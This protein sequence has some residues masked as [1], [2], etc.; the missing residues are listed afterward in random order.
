VQLF[1]TKYCLAAHLAILAVAPLFLSPYAVGWI[2]AIAAAWMFMEPSRVNDELPHDARLRVARAV[3][4]DPLFWTSVVVA[5][6]SLVRWLNGGIAQ[7]YDAELAKWYI[8]ESAAPMLPGSAAGAGAREF[9]GAVAFAVVAQ[10]CRHALG[11]LAR[12]AFLF[13]ASSLAGLSAAVIAALHA[14][15]AGIAAVT[16]CVE[17]SLENPVFTGSVFGAHLVAGTVSLVVA[18]E[19]KWRWT[20]PISLLAVGGNA[21]GLFLCAPAWTVA[22]FAAAWAVAFLYSFSYSIKALSGAGEFK[23]MVIAGMSLAFAAFLS[24]FALP[25]SSLMDRLSPFMT[26]DFFPKGYGAMRSE[27]SRIAIA[28]WK[29]HPW[30]GT[31]LASFPLDLKFAQNVEWGLLLPFHS[32]ALNGY[33]QLLAERGVLGALAFAVPLGLLLW[34]FFS[35]LWRGFRARRLPHPA[36]WVGL[37]VLLSVAVEAAVEPAFAE[38][39]MYVALSAFLAV[40]SNSFPKE[41]QDG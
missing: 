36:C 18:F 28:A 11:K 37:L 22:L 6:V 39:G 23:F 32:S 14:S 20:V 38:P 21:A 13:M 9:A 16:S 12:F 30:L 7:A 24:M 17:F 34:S 8:A 2:A 27:L 29:G 31:G 5:A 33:L 15:G 26:G 40:S 35:R 3:W 10:G 19:R 4:G 25:E 1:I 41:N